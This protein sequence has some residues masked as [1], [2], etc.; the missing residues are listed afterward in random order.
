MP[1]KAILTKEEFEAL[2]EEHKQL[3]MEQ[4]GKFVFNGEIEDVTGLKRALAATRDE[5]KKLKSDLQATID[6]YKDIDPERAREAQKKLD[7]I[8]EKNLLDAGKVD[9]LVAV[10]VER[11]KTDYENQITAFNKRIAGLED[12]NRGHH[13]RLSELLI[14]SAIREV[15][16]ANGVKKAALPDV[17][18]RGKQVWTLKDNVPTPMKGDQILYGKDPNK[19]LQMD[20]WV[21]GLQQEA[22]HL[23]EP[24]S[25]GGAQ[26][27]Q[28][29]NSRVVRISREDARVTSKYRA[30]REQAA[31]LGVELQIA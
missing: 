8:E 28:Q 31:K 14:D 11:M 15:A 22:A 24:S 13:S 18:S 10:K 17:I 26:N 6:K 27:T 25:G 5:N 2:A 4:D 20:E 1:L 30:A 16:L 19:P 9:E 12:E 7:E 3:Y 23:F 21:T 29:G